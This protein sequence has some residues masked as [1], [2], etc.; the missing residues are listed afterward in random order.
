[1]HKIIESI[2]IEREKVEKE[3]T[4]QSHFWTIID[5]HT[6]KI[7]SGLVVGAVALCYYM[8]PSTSK[9]GPLAEDLESVKHDLKKFK[10][11]EKKYHMNT[12][13]LQE[14]NEFKKLGMSLEKA[15]KN[16]SVDFNTISADLSAKII[17]YSD[18]CG[19]K[20][21]LFPELDML[22]NA[23][24]NHTM[25]EQA[26]ADIYGAGDKILHVYLENQPNMLD[27]HI[28][29]KTIKTILAK[30]KA[31]LTAMSRQEQ[32]VLLQPVYVGKG[33]EKA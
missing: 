13:T 28:K 14:G 23:D 1:L 20:Q 3:L 24:K 33:K 7:M 26:L 22:W 2:R 15:G 4:F 5:E 17:T 31:D 11:L 27:C 16:L 25:Y 10:E 12:L 9:S 8:M 29:I 18:L 21:H 6:G 32:L 30:Y 19:A